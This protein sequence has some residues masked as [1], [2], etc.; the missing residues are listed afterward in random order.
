MPERLEDVLAD[1]SL[2]KRK[3]A[4]SEWSFNNEQVEKKYGPFVFDRYDWSKFDVDKAD[5]AVLRLMGDPNNKRRK[6]IWSGVFFTI[7]AKD[8]LPWLTAENR[9]WYPLVE[10]YREEE[11]SDEIK[12][13]SAHRRIGPRN[14]G[15][16]L[17]LHRVISEAYGAEIQ[18][19]FVPDHINGFSLDNRPINLR[20][21]TGSVNNHNARRLRTKNGI[22]GP[23]VEWYDK[24][25]TTV[26]GV[27][28]I[29]GVKIRSDKVWPLADQIEAQRWYIDQL[30]QRF[31]D[32]WAHDEKSVPLPEFPPLRSSY[33]SMPTRGE[34]LTQEIP[35]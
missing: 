17:H 11:R 19:G 1:D 20:S 15:K 32:R 10:H 4:E 28:E 2:L 14:A 27:I 12:R 5:F 35:F 24:A 30:T 13:V 6:S 22:L 3:E 29:D 26:G 9:R 18:T 23:G 8:D 33:R 34:V 16:A 31:G 21:V 7:V 25:R